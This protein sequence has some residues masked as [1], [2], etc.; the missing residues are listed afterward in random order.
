MCD[1][2]LSV[3]S[4]RHR[5]F[6]SIS[7]LKIELCKS[8]LLMVLYSV[9]GFDRIYCGDFFF[10]DC[11]SGFWFFLYPN[12]LIRMQRL[13]S[14]REGGYPYNGRNGKAPSERGT[15]SGFKFMKAG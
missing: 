11:R 6:R 14:V 3:C 2:V 10:G 8:S 7:F 9:F 5:R 13:W 4:T 12:P 15:F 1:F